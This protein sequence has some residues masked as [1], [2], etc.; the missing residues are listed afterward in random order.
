MNTTLNSG[1]YYIL[2]MCLHLYDNIGLK[3][4]ESDF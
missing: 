2:H 1:L 4:N 3:L